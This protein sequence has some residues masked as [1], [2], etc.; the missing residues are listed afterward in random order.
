MDVF[1]WRE[2]VVGVVGAILGWLTRHFGPSRK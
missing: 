1:P 2:I